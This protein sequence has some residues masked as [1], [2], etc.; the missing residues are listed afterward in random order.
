MNVVHW[1][2]GFFTAIK[3]II[4]SA[5]VI[6][7]MLSLYLRPLLFKNLATIPDVGMPYALQEPALFVDTGGIRKRS[8]ALGLLEPFQ[9][10]ERSLRNPS[11]SDHSNAGATV[12]YNPEA[13]VED[14][15]ARDALPETLTIPGLTSMTGWKG[16]VTTFPADKQQFDTWTRSHGDIYSSKYSSATQINATNVHQLELAWSLDTSLTP[17]GPR[18]A[19]STETNPIFADG[20]LFSAT[21]EWTIVAVE[22]RSGK[23]VWSFRSPESIARRGMI[24]WPGNKDHGAR[25]YT[26]IGSRVVA[27]DTKTGHRVRSFG[28]DG[29]ARTGVSVVAPLIHNGA[30]IVA[31]NR[32]PEPVL[33]GLDLETGRHLWSVT[34]HP[35]GHSFHGGT[36]WGGMSLDPARNMV[37]LGSGNP[38]PAA[39]GMGR[40][41]DDRNSNS[42]IAVD[43]G[44]Q[45]IAWTFQDT[46]HDL[47][48][49]DIPSPPILTT[50][51]I[52]GTPIDVVIGL[53]KIGTVIMLERKTG[54]PVF[55]FRLSRAPTSTVPGEVTAPYQP[56]PSIP[57]P[58]INLEFTPADISD[59]DAGATA[60]IKFQL[61]NDLFGRFVP[62]TVGQGVIT[63]GVSGGAQ[64]PGAA[65]D[66]TRGMLYV[67]VNRI[68]TKV[69]LFL[70]STGAAARPGGASAALYSRTCGSC[71]GADRNGKF[72]EKSEA[73]SVDVPS[74]N[75]ISFRPSADK[76]FKAD[77]FRHRHQFADANLSPS[78]TQLDNLRSYFSS[79]DSAVAAAKDFHINY[80]WAN[81]F[82]RHG[83]SGSRPPWGGIVAV[84][85]ATGKRRWFAPTGQIKIDGK[86]REVGTTNFGG[87]IATAGNVLF[88][89]GTADG[90]V[91][92]LNASTGAELWSYKMAAAGSAPPTT[93]TMDGVQYVAVVASGGGFPGYDAKASMIYAFRLQADKRH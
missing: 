41:G 42:V 50:V 28:E 77:Y 14:R 75:G 1:R 84:D 91:R 21:T 85:L 53:T 12:P 68:A 60:D 7:I 26:P 5:I 39:V 73:K 88:A 6:G 32:D 92:A 83:R 59:L 15:G 20:L 4:G 24:Y 81:L 71:H 40:T 19:A 23:L 33:M 17:G 16:T 61:E 47:W 31:V 70:T 93:F 64:W 54:Q 25:I 29:F 56:N 30:L 62:P 3:W 58:L 74:L 51:S 45:K 76:F 55:D 57:E 87:V 18:R 49:F 22:P 34:L 67:P 36:I 80:E 37:F 8:A 63:F 46:R 38:R 43:I 44:K 2:S 52:D 11:K 66:H 48:D 35:K 72:E 9:L 10:L 65:V 90:L 89:T 79:W 82:D 13:P 69:A 86:M 27:L 78:Q